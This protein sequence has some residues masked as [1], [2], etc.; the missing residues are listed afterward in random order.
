MI[1]SQR[2]LYRAG[3]SLAGNRGY[4]AVAGSRIGGAAV[5]GLSRAGSFVSGGL[6]TL[7]RVAGI[8]GSGGGAVAGGA[9]TAGGTAAMAIVGGAVAAGA[10]LVGIV[11]AARA[12]SSVFRSQANELEEFSGAIA[13]AKINI[14][15]QRLERQVE[16]SPKD[17]SRRSAG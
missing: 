14:Q 3:R 9:A 10:A 8:G 1:N 17:W 16:S 13:G 5:N 11:L 15:A 4:Q 7:G 12:L 2:L 6:G